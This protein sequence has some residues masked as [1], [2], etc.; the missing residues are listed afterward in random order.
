MI[1]AENIKESGFTLI[2]LL[3]TVAIIGILSSIAIPAFTDYK[4]RA[5]NTMALSDLRNGITSQEAY[6]AD[7]EVYAECEN[8]QCE[9]ILPGF[10][11]SDGV[12]F[13]TGLATGSTS[14]YL[15]GTCHIKGSSIHAYRNDT[16]ISITTINDESLHSDCVD[17]L[18]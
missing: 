11:L 18:F 10:V 3:V 9:S 13:D 17:N 5:F 7:N 1:R 6:F 12:G 2:E 16:N 15:A 8:D 4:K 14:R